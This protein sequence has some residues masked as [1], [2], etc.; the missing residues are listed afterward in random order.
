MRYKYGIVA[1]LAIAIVG[2]VGIYW[3]AVA[4]RAVG[5]P[6]D[7]VLQLRDAGYE[8]YVGAAKGS[9]FPSRIEVVADAP[10]V[11]DSD[12]VW[13]WSAPSIKATS[14]LY[15]PDHLLV[16]WPSKQDFETPFGAFAVASSGMRMSL[17]FGEEPSSGGGEPLERLSWEAPNV[18]LVGPDISGYAGRIEAHLRRAVDDS[19]TSGR[20]R[21]YVEIEGLSL[22]RPD[23]SSAP[24]VI[25]R[26]AF[27]GDLV[28]AERPARGPIAVT[29]PIALRIG[30]GTLAWANAGAAFSGGV[31]LETAPASGMLLVGA[32]GASGLIARLE[33]LGWVSRDS[34]A[35]LIA[36]VGADGAL[37]GDWTLKDGVLAFDGVTLAEVE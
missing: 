30:A 14:V 17:V 7:L 27:D 33:A 28:F 10:R 20:Y 4:N 18:S 9:G 8:A 2:A 24:P 6:I 3:N 22:R 5:I 34:A 13:M 15:R 16:D 37:N 35:S 23:I 1:G 31:D 26:I 19:P 32:T 21:L 25:E 11:G 36:R 12:G 29:A